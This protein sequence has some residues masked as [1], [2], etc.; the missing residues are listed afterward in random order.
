[1]VEFQEEAARLDGTRAG[2]RDRGEL[3]GAVA[4]PFITG[5]GGHVFFLSPFEKAAALAGSL[6]RRQPF[7][8]GNKRAAAFG[9][10]RILSLFDFELVAE[11]P[12][13]LA[14][15]IQVDSDAMTEDDFAI[16]LEARSIPIEDEPPAT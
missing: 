11:P 4:R 9:V 1:L 7:V 16:W 6:I 8:D 2:I 12:D 15:I 14:A 3:E 13:L 5:G 10:G